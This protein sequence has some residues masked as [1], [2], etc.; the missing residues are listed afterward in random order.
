MTDMPPDPHPEL[1]LGT[2]DHS[3][4]LKTQ[5]FHLH[6]ELERLAEAA[7]RFGWYGH[8]WSEMLGWADNINRHFNPP[9][10]TRIRHGESAPDG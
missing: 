10:T 6:R 4:L 8:L 9:D 3:P 5:A 1:T 7:A 2:D